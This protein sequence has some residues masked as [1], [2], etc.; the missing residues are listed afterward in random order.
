MVVAKV[1]VLAKSAVAVMTAVQGLLR[2]LKPGETRAT[3]AQRV[4]AMLVAKGMLSGLPPAMKMLLTKTAGLDQPGL[5][6]LQMGW[7][8]GKGINPSPD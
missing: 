3:L 6:E 8:R 5:K 7:W 2:P 1:M 4:K